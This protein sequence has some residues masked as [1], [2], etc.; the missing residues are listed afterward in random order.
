MEMC[1]LTGV[2]IYSEQF[3]L[4]QNG[5]ALAI[6]ICFSSQSCL[7]QHN[8]FSREQ[9]SGHEGMGGCGSLGGEGAEGA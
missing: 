4:I 6:S 9:C 8:A 5:G 2:N 1:I 3:Q 7:G